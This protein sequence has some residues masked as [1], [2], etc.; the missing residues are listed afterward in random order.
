MEFANSKALCRRHEYC[1]EAGFAN[2]GFNFPTIVANFPPS[3]NSLRPPGNMRREPI[4]KVTQ[5]KS[6]RRYAST[7]NAAEIR[8]APARRI[9]EISPYGSTLLLDLHRRREMGQKLHKLRPNLIWR[10]THFPNPLL[11]YFALYKVRISI[12]I[13]FASMRENSDITTRP[14]PHANAIFYVT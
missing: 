1:D 2:Q 14:R 3:R 7:R 10:A 9:R 11:T 6:T 13:S 4:G 5:Q 12:P 8:T